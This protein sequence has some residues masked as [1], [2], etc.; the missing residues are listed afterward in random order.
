MK[1]GKGLPGGGFRHVKRRATQ[2][3]IAKRIADKDI[4]V[5]L[6]IKKVDAL[7]KLDEIEQAKGGVVHGK[8]RTE[9]DTLE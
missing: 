2:S 3:E 8:R 1:T 9:K 7:A 6:M 4:F 5:G